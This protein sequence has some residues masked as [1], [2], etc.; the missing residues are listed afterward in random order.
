MQETTKSPHFELFSGIQRL[1]ANICVVE[2]PV[3][4]RDVA[5]MASLTIRQRTPRPKGGQKE[6]NSRGE[7]P[8]KA[9]LD[10]PQGPH[11][12]SFRQFPFQSPKSGLQ[13]PILARVLLFR[14]CCFHPHLSVHRLSRPTEKI[15]FNQQV[16]IRRE[17]PTLIPPKHWNLQEQGKTNLAPS[18]PKCSS[19]GFLWQ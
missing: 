8:K 17:M 14:T 15:I 7:T 10:P 19:Q 6:E 16:Q 4:Q 12:T 3:S 11:L 9:L 13:R 2:N 18:I 5:G 1:L